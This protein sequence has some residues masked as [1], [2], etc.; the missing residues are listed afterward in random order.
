MPSFADNITPQQQQAWNLYNDLRGAIRQQA[1]LFLFIGKTLKEIRDTKIYRYLGEG[2][3][4]TFDQFLNDPDIGIRKASTLYLYIRIYEYYCLQ[5]AMP[6]DEV[7]TIPINRLMYLLPALKEKSNEEAKGI[8]EQIAPL[9]THDYDVVVKEKGLIDN[10]RPKV[11]RHKVCGKWIVDVDT[12]L[13]CH[14]ETLPQ[15]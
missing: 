10:Q 5:L 7:V 4:E 13:L 8:V 9:T 2:G 1:K 3:Y 6:E 12:G 11:Y 14:C 15:K